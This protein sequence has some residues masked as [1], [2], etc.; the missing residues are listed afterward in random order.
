MKNQ[1]YYSVYANKEQVQERA[2]DP[3]LHDLLSHLQVSKSKALL[4]HITKSFMGLEG[5][6]SRLFF[7]FKYNDYT[8][9]SKLEAGHRIFVHGMKGIHNLARST[10]YFDFYVSEE[11]TLGGR[12]FFDYV[13]GTEYPSEY[14]LRTKDSQE[15]GELLTSAAESP[16]ENKDNV[17]INNRNR[18][19]VC[20]IAERLW[21]SQLEDS[22][23][24]LVILLPKEEI[25]EESVD[26]L[27]QLYLLLPEQLRLNMGFAVDCSLDDI[28][29]LIVECDLPVHIFTA[30]AENK[31]VL[32]ERA[33]EIKYPLVY[34]DATDPA[35]E[36]CDAEKLNLLDKLSRKLS[37]SSDAKMA[38]VEK[39]V[40]EDG[41]R[42]VSFKNLAEIF[43]MMQKDDYF[44]WDRKDLETLENVIDAYQEQRELMQDADLKKEALYSFYANMLPEKE[45]AFQMNDRVLKNVKAEND[46]VLTFF[47]DHFSYGK[48]IEAAEQMKKKI[49]IAADKRQKAALEERDQQWQNKVS[50]LEKEHSDALT[51]YETKLNA[52][53]QRYGKLEEQYQKT[54]EEHASAVQNL[55]H[56]HEEKLA[57]T[58]RDWTGKYTR[59]QQEKERFV[60]DRE[61]LEYTN[62][63]LLQNTETLEKQNK[64]LNDQLVRLSGSRAGVEIQQLHMEKSILEEKL[65]KLSAENKKVSVRAKKAK[66]LFGVSAALAV[67]FLAGTIVFG[68]LT[69]KNSGDVKELKA[70]RKTL[71]E[72]GTQQT[73]LLEEKELE[74]E[75]LQKENSEK[76]AEIENL[77]REKSEIERSSNSAAPTE[78]DTEEGTEPEGEF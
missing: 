8:N 66:I 68:V 75:N 15:I 21:S 55:K 25:Y 39:K 71:E 3:E 51:G 24:R 20:R 63:E 67:L 60:R 32:Q 17:Y 31:N 29:N 41:K 27:K 56:A 40:R 46:E 59:L 2:V 5:N 45:Y 26:L 44:W 42:L 30:R 62:R 33:G 35:S 1:L 38:Y 74:I 10:P 77:Q 18:E 78:Q 52:E 43:E 22:T 72:T 53:Q 12:K 6:K 70:E 73:K 54:Q 76:T 28:K 19:L 14:E 57:Q 9:L 16:V 47:R 49:C 65:E 48:V 64:D 4:E 11:E 36:P 23:S 58:E 34:F 37:S 50:L 61:E 69:A 7:G 13:F